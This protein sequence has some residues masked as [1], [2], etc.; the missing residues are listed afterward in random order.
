[1]T[2]DRQTSRTLSLI[3]AFKGKTAPITTFF[4]KSHGT[5]FL[6]SWNV[7][8]LG[9][10]LQRIDDDFTIDSKGKSSIKSLP[11]NHSISYFLERHGSPDIL[12][13][14]EHKIPLHQVTSRSEP[15]GISSLEGY[16]S[17]WSCC[18]D[19]SKRGFNGVVTFA[20][21]GSVV[22]ADSN[23]LDDKDLDMQ[24]RC[25]MTDHGEFVVF[26]VYVPCSDGTTQSME[27]KLRFLAALERSIRRQRL[28]RSK[29]VIVAG[30]LNMYS[31]QDDIHWTFRSLNVDC[32]LKEVEL[33]HS[34]Q[35]TILPQWKVDLYEKWSEISDALRNLVVVPVTTKNSSTGET[36]EKY[37]ARITFNNGRKKVF[38]GSHHSS[39]DDA[40][41]QF[42]F[43]KTVTEHEADENYVSLDTLVDLMSKVGGIKWDD[44]T[45]KELS[46]YRGIATELQSVTTTWLHRI[47]DEFHL[48][49]S[50]RF[51]YPHTKNR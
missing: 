24:G 4:K 32:I 21:E 31:T 33:N 43:G 11:R 41:R 22:I 6:M 1:M 48:I 38:I 46:D 5:M 27:D 51:L 45:L 37:R 18:I 2:T 23:P 25:V 3:H 14:Q 29:K 10:T 36:F 15:F 42:S 13:I 12:C 26:N 49:D 20:K 50:F 44:R 8:G 7:A 17:F 35:S 28:E 34:T 40:L 19:P 30:D 9:P 47:M 16:E 39:A